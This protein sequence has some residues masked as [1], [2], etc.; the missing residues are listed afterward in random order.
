MG[1]AIFFYYE[2]LYSEDESIVLPRCLD[3][4]VVGSLVSS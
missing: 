1:C 2:D 3:A 4:G